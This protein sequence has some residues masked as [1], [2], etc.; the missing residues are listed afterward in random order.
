MANNQHPLNACTFF[1]N[2]L[3]RMVTLF[4]Y[5]KDHRMDDEVST[6]NTRRRTQVPEIADFEMPSR[7]K[8]LLKNL[9]FRSCSWE[10]PKFYFRVVQLR[11]VRS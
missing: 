7:W 4:I 2:I 6:K 3:R 8:F 9:K 1:G 11:V 5:L 10:S